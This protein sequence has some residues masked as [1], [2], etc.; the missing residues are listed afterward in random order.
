MTA[1]LSMNFCMLWL[2]SKTVS[3][4]LLSV[5]TT[6]C[7]GRRSTALGAAWAARSRFSITESGM[8]SPL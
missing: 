3:Y 1:P 6:I 2:P 5:M 8:A 4:W 7:Q